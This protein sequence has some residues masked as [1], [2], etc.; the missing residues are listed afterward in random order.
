MVINKTVKFTISYVWVFLAV[1]SLTS[2]LSAFEVN[3]T[4]DTFEKIL[5]PLV[6]KNQIPGYY[7]SV[8]KDGKKV[9]ERSKGYADIASRLIPQEDTL[10]SIQGFTTL[11]TALTIL[12]LADDGVIEI[13]DPVEKYIPEF[14]EMTVAPNG[15]YDRDQEIL[16]RS[17]IETFIDAYL[18]F[19]SSD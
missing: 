9:Y 19:N 12:K 13:S 2:D 8:S 14:S 5:D 16:D 3:R 1:I 10:F 17:H 15:M 18:R 6:D 4:L 7:F 11:F